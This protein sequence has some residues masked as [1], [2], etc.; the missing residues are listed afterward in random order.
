LTVN[1]PRRENL[2]LPKIK[3]LPNRIKGSYKLLNPKFDEIED[4][5]DPDILENK[6][7]YFNDLL[8]GKIKINKY[9]LESVK[10]TLLNKIDFNENTEWYK[11]SI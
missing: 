9:G 4:T 8:N 6:R 3:L 11:V 2:K 7:T 5:Y 10:Y 1:S